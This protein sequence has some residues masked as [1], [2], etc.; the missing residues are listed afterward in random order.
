MNRFYI[1]HEFMLMRKSKKNIMF[2]FFLTAFLLS[3]CFMILPNK[4]TI[5]SFDVEE[6]KNQL[7]DMAVLQ[8]SRE[9]RGAT[10]VIQ[11]VGMSV[12]AMDSRS[13][14]IRKS[15]LYAYEDEQLTRY[16]RFKTLDLNPITFTQ[17][18]S[19]FPNSPFPGKDRHHLYEQTALRYES[20]LAG[21]RPISSELIEQKTALQTLQNLL[22][23]PMTYL[24]VFC[25]I[26]F[27]S[28]VLT[29]DRRNRTILQGMPISW[30]RSINLKTWTAFIYTIA[31]LLALL[32]VGMTILTIQ[33]GLGYWDIKMPI[34]IPGEAFGTVVYEMIPIG[35]FIS[36]AMVGVFILVYLFTRLNMVLSL[37]L[38]NEWLV[39]M[40]STLLL[41][42]ER[43]YFSRTLRE[44]FGIEIGYFPQTYF[45]FG[46][47]ITGD[48]NFLVNLETITYSKGLLLFGIAILITEILLLVISRIVN[49]QRFYQL[50]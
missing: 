16:L 11:M 28:D 5:D 13:Y 18:E 19:L 20:Y 33:N 42:S 38:K 29:R 37:L 9:A 39:L 14:T 3:Y 41:F 22:L 43:L 23:G 12:Y 40:I 7:E 25:A 48:K 44:L 27:S 4:Q 47:V 32:V 31:V 2:I 10:G 50:N 17:D 36:Q 8:K 46:K 34:T 6:M 26:Y 30:Y 15:M 45:E 24:L 35:K 1:K 49:K 21:Q